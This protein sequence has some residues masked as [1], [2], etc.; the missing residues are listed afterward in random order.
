MISP[1]LRRHSLTAPIGL[2]LAA[3]C[4]LTACGEDGPQLSAAGER[5]RQVAADNGC[6]ACHGNQGQGGIGPT[7]IGL[8]DA[9]VE[10]ND[11]TMVVANDDYLRRSILD[12]NAEQ[13]AD[14][15][16]SMPIAGLEQSQVE[17]LI[18]YIRD[19]K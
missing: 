16:I 14:Y 13:V 8:A 5:G 9:E 3:V 18:A 19:L 1:H 12:P 11:G 2:A 7:W 4:T 6:A 17:D 10:L 15:T